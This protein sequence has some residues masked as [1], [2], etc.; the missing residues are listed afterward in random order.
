MHSDRGILPR[1]PRSQEWLIERMHT[2]GYQ[3]NKKG[4]CF[5]I[6]HMAMQATLSNDYDNFYRR[7]QL[8]N[9]IPTNQF[10]TKIKALAKKRLDLITS[11][12][13]VSQIL[14]DKLT[15]QEKDEFE[16]SQYF[17]EKLSALNLSIDKLTEENITLDLKEK[18]RRKEDF[19]RNAF[20]QSKIDVSLQALSHDEQLLLEAPALFEGIDLY[21]TPR[22]YPDLLPNIYTGKPQDASRSIPLTLSKKLENQD[23]NNKSNIAKLDS[24]SG[25]YNTKALLTTLSRLSKTVAETIPPLANSF[26]IILNNFQH[27]IAISF[28][29]SQSN[30][31]TLIDANQLQLSTRKISDE[32][33]A[34][35][36]QGAFTDNEIS[37]INTEIYGLKSDELQLNAIL[38]KWKQH[39]EWQSIHKPTPY[40]AQLRDSNNSSWL[41]MAACMGDIENTTRL[42]SLNTD[43]NIVTKHNSTPLH[44][45]S[46]NGHL[47][48]VKALIKNKANI[49]FINDKKATPLL[50]A[51]AGGH[52]DIV[53]Y[54]LKNGAIV[55]SVTIN[56]ATPLYRAAEN[57]QIELVELLLKNGADPDLTHINGTTPLYIAA[58]HGHIEIVKKLL[59]AG[60]NPNTASK[61][62]HMPLFTAAYYGHTEVVK[63]LLASD[64]KA[65]TVTINNMS[66]L[67]VA[68]LSGQLDIVNILLNEN[69]NITNPCIND[70][71][72]FTKIA[73]LLN[74]NDAMHHYIQQHHCVDGKISITPAQMAAMMGHH[75]IA[76]LINLKLIENNNIIAKE[77]YRLITEEISL[78]TD[79]EDNDYLKTL[80]SLKSAII[81]PEN[82]DE[83]IFDI[84]NT[85]QLTS[86]VDIKK[87]RLFSRESSPISYPFIQKLMAEF[88]YDMPSDSLKSHKMSIRR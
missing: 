79:K 28:D 25:V 27:T 22:N 35:A 53:K 21:H 78:V 74:I 9:A 37:C 76:D 75:H 66:P 72:Y 18:K 34:S 30:K 17:I 7:L 11:A 67:F 61:N 40:K 51:T 70:I 38:T 29:P 14:F 45:A 19:L 23:K 69:I 46:Q 84:I 63:L 1:I 73:K 56:G 85:H 32:T 68:A 77:I 42:L 33:L 8:I 47:H 59:N 20:I 71:A 39:R 88:G 83:F 80:N 62:G 57:G 31:W 55:N 24:Y 36:I 3:P 4:I 5:G 10:Q 60:A 48:I 86:A 50:Y 58:Q 52:I 16:N 12:K 43:P 54:L 82:Q 15:S 64:A 13:K 6:A 49:N 65:D 87:A 81:Q 41:Y 2:L 44:I 26:T